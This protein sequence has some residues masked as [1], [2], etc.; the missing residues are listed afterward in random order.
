MRIP[1][2]KLTTL[3]PGAVLETGVALGGPVELR[4]QGRTVAR[5]EL[6]DVEGEVGVRILSVVDPAAS[7]AS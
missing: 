6:V 1:L 5:G 7:T 2:G 4:V 3:A